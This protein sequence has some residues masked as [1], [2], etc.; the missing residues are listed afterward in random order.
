M[1]ALLALA[2]AAEL[3][4]PPKPETGYYTEVGWATGLF[5]NMAEDQARYKAI[6]RMVEGHAAGFGATARNALRRAITAAGAVRYRGGYCVTVHVPRA[7]VTRLEDEANALDAALATVAA[8]VRAKA[9]ARDIRLAIAW[10]N[11]NSVDF[12]DWMRNTVE[13]NLKGARLSEAW[14]PSA[15]DVRITLAASGERVSARVVADRESLGGFGFPSD[16][17]GVAAEGSGIAVARIGLPEGGRPGA[18]GLRVEVSSPVADGVACTGEV[19]EVVM[20]TDRPARVRLYSV[21]ARGDAWLV[22]PLSAEVFPGA[23][24]GSG[25]HGDVL[26]R[27]A[28][29]GAV[30]GGALG[31]QMALFPSGTGDE[32]FVAVAIPPGA[33]WPEPWE[34][35][36]HLPTPFDGSRYPAGSSVATATYSMR[37]AGSYECPYREEWVE[38]TRQA[39]SD[40]AA[41]GLCQ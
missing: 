34:G 30:I 4:P 33:S 32:R 25:P 41:A 21:D 28:P 17:F 22:W 39:Q 14:D 23:P 18:G 3:C 27:V 9:G 1:I 13:A 20:R 7:A 11:G 10:S 2:G 5:G 12:G 8:E 6:E 37:A 29:D 38:A 40:Q 24:R 16:L 35:Y 31:V 26:G 19:G 36:C 15:L